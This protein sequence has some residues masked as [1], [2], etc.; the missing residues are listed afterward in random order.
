M[1]VIEEKEGGFVLTEN[2]VSTVLIKGGNNWILV[3][4]DKALDKVNGNI[5]VFEL[6]NFVAF[7]EVS[8]DN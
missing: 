3:F 8:E 4:L 6:D 5:V 1:V 2:S 7:V